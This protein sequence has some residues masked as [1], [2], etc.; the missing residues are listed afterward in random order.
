MMLSNPT[1]L[2]RGLRAPDA[3]IYSRQRIVPI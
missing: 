3:W 2:P 1:G